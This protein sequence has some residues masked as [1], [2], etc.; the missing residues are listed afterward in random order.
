MKQVILIMGILS[1]FGCKSQK[2]NKSNFEKLTSELKIKLRQELKTDSNK[3]FSSEFKRTT[4]LENTIISNYGYE[5]IKL[6]FEYRNSENYYKLG[7]FPKNSPWI[8]LNN[9]S[10]NE[11]IS[12]NF[13]PLSTKIPNLIASIKERC[14]FIYLEKR[15]HDW[16]L[17]YLMEMKLHDGRDYYRVYT[18]GTPLL[19]PNPNKSLAKYN[20]NIPTDLKKFYTIHNGFGE[21]YDAYYVMAN[22]DIK[23]MAELMDPICE[24][25]NSYPEGYTF[26]ELLEFFPDGG[27]NAQ[28]FYR[29]KRN[30][31]VDWDHE[32]W[33]ISGE[34]GF[35]EFINERMSEI[36][37]E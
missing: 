13:S 1:F 33:E 26:K 23:I 29:N 5:G 3:D 11:F 36:D 21:V 7:E 25:Q 12:E 6:L 28:C 20:W 16:H 24:E 18:G 32:V 19:N 17:H 14:K 4:N 35:Y 30:L 22:E 10:I 31:T 27:G 37:E 34:I 2:N 9:K 15:E 8:K